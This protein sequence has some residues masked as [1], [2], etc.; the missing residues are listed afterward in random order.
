MKKKGIGEKLHLK[1][2]KK[3]SSGFAWVMGRPAR[4]TRFFRVVVPTSLLTN[5]DRSSCRV[6]PS[7]H[8]GFNICEFN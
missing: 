5:S 2:K 3:V 4:S 6:D 7:G 1:K 8:S